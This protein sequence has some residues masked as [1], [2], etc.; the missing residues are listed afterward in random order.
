MRISALTAAISAV[1]LLDGTNSLAAQPDPK[2]F[3]GDY[4]VMDATCTMQGA[5]CS[6]SKVSISVADQFAGL[7]IKMDDTLTE[8]GE[9]NCPAPTSTRDIFCHESNS[10]Q[11]GIHFY[12]M[13]SIEK[14]ASGHYE[15][16]FSVSTS[17]WY[18]N[19]SFSRQLFT[20]KKIN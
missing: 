19:L 6:F 17:D 8:I 12:Q 5:Q 1:L 7:T 20:L 3:V 9:S 13:A 4:E 14:M 15:L 11:G 2:Q 16:E 18:D 10:A